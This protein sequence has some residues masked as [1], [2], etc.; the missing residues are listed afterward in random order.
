LNDVHGAIHGTSHTAGEADD[1]GSAI[2]NCRD[3]MQRTFHSGAVIGIEC[4][5]ALGD[6]VDICPRDLLIGE[7]QFVFHITRRRQAAKINDDLDQFVTV[8]DLFHGV[9]KISGE[10]VQKNVEV[11]CNSVLCHRFLSF[12]WCRCQVSS[13]T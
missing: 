1:G 11:V 8:V 13:D 6:M 4:T 2:A 3:A 5:D 7:R 9:T 12:R 10:D